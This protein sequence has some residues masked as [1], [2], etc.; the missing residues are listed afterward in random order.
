[1]K[2]WVLSMVCTCVRRKRVKLHSTLPQSKM[3]SYCNW[4]L[5]AVGTFNQT[6]RHHLHHHHHHHHHHPHPPHPHPHPHPHPYHHH[7][8]YQHQLY[9]IFLALFCIPMAHPWPEVSDPRCFKKPAM[10]AEPSRCA[11]LVFAAPSTTLDPVLG[12]KKR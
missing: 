10:P 11:M 1:M 4:D 6:D 12:D 9:L 3:S 7:H 8:D 5:G 2:A